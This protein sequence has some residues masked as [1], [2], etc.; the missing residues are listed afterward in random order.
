MAAVMGVEH[1]FKVISLLVSKM[2][3]KEAILAAH[4]AQ[5]GHFGI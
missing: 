1:G 4:W 5:F 2:M 3:I